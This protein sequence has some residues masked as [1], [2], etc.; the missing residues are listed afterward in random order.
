[1]ACSD[2]L[3]K[4]PAI[5]SG[6]IGTYGPYTRPFKFYAPR[7]VRG[8]I[9]TPSVY[10]EATELNRYGWGQPFQAFNAE[11]PPVLEDIHPPLGSDQEGDPEVDSP[12]VRLYYPRE[13]GC[14]QVQRGIDLEGDTPLGC[15]DWRGTTNEDGVW[16]KG[17]KSRYGYSSW[18]HYLQEYFVGDETNVVFK[19]F[20][21]VNPDNS[22]PMYTTQVPMRSRVRHEGYGSFHKN[23]DGETYS[24]FTSGFGVGASNVPDYSLW[25]H[26]YQDKVYY[27]GLL[28][29]KTPNHSD[30]DQE[31]IYDAGQSASLPEQIKGACIRLVPPDIQYY[32]DIDDMAAY[33]QAV[34]A[35][36]EKWLTVVTD[37]YDGRDIRLSGAREATLRVYNKPLNITIATSQTLGAL[38]G[39]KYPLDIYTGADYTSKVALYK[40]A[41]TEAEKI[42]AR[43]IAIKSYGAWRLAHEEI[44]DDDTDVYGLINPGVSLRGGHPWMFNATG[45]TA[46]IVGAYS[47]PENQL[48]GG[49]PL[50]PAYQQAQKVTDEAWAEL[51]E[52][53]AGFEVYVT[54]PTLGTLTLDSNSV[55][56]GV[57]VS[58]DTALLNSKQTHTVTPKGESTLRESFNIMSVDYKGNTLVKSTV[59]RKYFTS[60]ETT[61]T[62]DP[63]KGTLSYYQTSGIDET[64]ELHT[65]FGTYDLHNNGGSTFTIDGVG[66]DADTGWANF[67]WDDDFKDYRIAIDIL[68]L[69]NDIIVTQSGD[70]S[71]TKLAEGSGTKADR[72]HHVHTDTEDYAK[73]ATTTYR[74]LDVFTDDY[75]EPDYPFLDLSMYASAP[76]DWDL[77]V[78]VTPPLLGNY[79]TANYASIAYTY[80]SGVSLSRGA[81]G[82]E[83]MCIHI[84]RNYQYHAGDP[85]ALYQNATELFITASEANPGGYSQGSK[86]FYNYSSKAKEHGTTLRSI[87]SLEEYNED[88]ICLLPIDY[89]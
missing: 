82:E 68:D 79:T 1:M 64:V 65:S 48:V 69:R 5:Q 72:V 73:V 39:E 71:Y 14:P 13:D 12:R 7:S 89:A 35:G 10:N 22:Q 76:E 31:S 29:A 77:E 50:N 8:F 83:M 70:N 30:L 21:A 86:R 19:E 66:G 47:H 53:Y 37:Q 18:V 60:R 45:T 74:D 81:G 78:F 55:E 41:G 15:I 49:F 42:L 52:Y 63:R 54:Y 23:P 51:T 17:P 38:D 3:G 4:E 58:W 32:R 84:G 44:Y 46:S 87:L 6:A 56:G 61:I 20:G 27:Q 80:S 40:S 88:E 59:T 16:F 26:I 67:R 75:V 2:S 43:N 33:H 25:E 36:G 28:L 9:V 57:S 24:S 34:A 62:G 11:D 85:R